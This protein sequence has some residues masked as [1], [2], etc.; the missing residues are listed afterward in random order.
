MGGVLA[1]LGGLVLLAVSALYALR[2]AAWRDKG[3]HHRRRHRLATI[4]DA[5]TQGVGGAKGRPG[6]A[7]MGWGR[8][9]VVSPGPSRAGSAASGVDDGMPPSGDAMPARTP[10]ERERDLA[11]LALRG[12]YDPEDLDLGAYG[13]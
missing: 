1:G 9:T 2:Q 13:G 4:G 10:A 6:S 3:A 7:W 5:T 12:S 8:A 11:A